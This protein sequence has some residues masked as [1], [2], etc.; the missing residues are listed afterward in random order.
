MIPGPSEWT[1]VRRTLQRSQDFF[2]VKGPRGER[3]HFAIAQ[4]LGTL[5]LFIAHVRTWTEGKIEAVPRDAVA[6]AV[7]AIQKE[8]DRVGAKRHK[9]TD[10]LLSWLRGDDPKYPAVLV[11]RLEKAMKA[12]V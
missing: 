8:D 4:Q 3:F 6:A 9:D 11:A 5:S 7:T 12:G 2:P 1:Q 10:R